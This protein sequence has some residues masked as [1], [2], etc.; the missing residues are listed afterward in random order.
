MANYGA[1]ELLNISP[2]RRKPV[3]GRTKCCQLERSAGPF[4]GKQA[5]TPDFTTEN[6]PY[7]LS[8]LAAAIKSSEFIF[9]PGFDGAIPGKVPGCTVWPD[10]AQN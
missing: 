7:L 8:D 6:I 10:L 3:V 1:A 9:S 5:G 2:N 4:L